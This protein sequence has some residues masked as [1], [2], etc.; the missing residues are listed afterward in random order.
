MIAGK[1]GEA[2]TRAFLLDR[3]WILER[4][5]DMEGAD[6]FIQR[7]LTSESL[8]SREPPKLG[9][10]QAKFYQD[11]KT[12]QFVHKEYIED[13]SG[14]PREEFFLLCHT[15]S[16]DNARMY[17]ATAAEVQATFK[18]SRSESRAGQ[19]CIPGRE[20][21]SDR[22]LVTNRSR[23]LKRIEQALINTN[24]Q[25]NRRFLSWAL[26]SIEIED[27][28]DSDFLEDIDN[29]YGSIPEEFFELR[30]RAREAMYDL[31]DYMQILKE[32]AETNSPKVAVS[33]AER[34]D[35]DSLQHVGR[36]L[37]DPEFAEA[38]IQHDRWVQLL[39]SAGLLE[40]PMQHFVG[41]CLI[42]SRL[43]A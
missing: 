17:L 19:Y 14:K 7:R 10:V 25:S 40:M 22:W 18:V 2:R 12:T 11:E 41:D 29:W 3:F 31:D 35:S 13:E 20:I 37:F 24:F 6:S 28:I 27:S 9:A 16:E 43:S 30:K 21:L 8:L 33:A 36:D 42:S 38:V 5:I 32:I 15:G 23:A 4:S 39:K 34:F 1:A 26:P